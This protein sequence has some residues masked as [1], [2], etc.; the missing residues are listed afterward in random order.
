MVS[1][2]KE[3]P[4]YSAR[5][6]DLAGFRDRLQTTSL[7]ELANSRRLGDVRSGFLHYCTVRA[8]LQA[9]V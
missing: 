9:V 5:A 7:L 2:C 3:T 8:A 1:L 6:R 4:L